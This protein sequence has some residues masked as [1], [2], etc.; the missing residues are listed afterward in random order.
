[1]LSLSE[2]DF[3][4]F[5]GRDRELK[6]I[7]R[8]S[9]KTRTPMFYRTN[10]YIH[11]RRLFV[12]IKDSAEMI[13]SIYGDDFDI[14][15]ALTLALVHDDAEIVTGD[16]QLYYKERMSVEELKEVDDDEEKAIGVLC[17]R[18]PD[19]ING[20]SYRDLL[21]H[22]LR[23]DCIEA[24]IVSYFDKI[25]A[26]CEALHELHAGNFRFEGPAHNYVW[27]V[28]D[29]PKKFPQ[30][31]N[32]LFGEEPLIKYPQNLDTDSM[33]AHG[34][35]HNSNSVREKTG[36]EFYDRWK[37]LTIENFGES[38]LTEIKEKEE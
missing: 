14:D 2:V 9:M 38:V 6:K 25:D 13:N 18:W 32:F 12:L 24:Q 3:K 19:K 28:R 35:F 1:M 8:Y 34:D 36:I 26:F 22:A 17:E 30:L 20:F 5:D 15:K 27:R 7:I 33:L 4:G 31:G 37:E 11:S 16:I 29:F 23:K 10:L 21:F